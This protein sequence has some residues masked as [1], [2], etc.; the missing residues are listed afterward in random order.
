MKEAK[1]SNVFQA[2]AQ[3]ALIVAVSLTGVPANAEPELQPKAACTVR[4]A[5]PI[6]QVMIPPTI[7]QLAAIEGFSGEAMVR[8]ELD[9]TGIPRNPAIVK[10]T[11]YPILDQ[12]ALKSVLEQQF[13]PEIRDCEAVAGTY[14]VAVEFVR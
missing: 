9:T 5:L 8:V 14:G 13:T 3:T 7:P 10:S 1:M 4:N 6:L 11:G 12:A 2:I